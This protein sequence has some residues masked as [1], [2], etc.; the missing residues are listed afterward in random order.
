MNKA[1]IIFGAIVTKLLLLF[2]SAV[3]NHY[4]R[5]PRMQNIM[6]LII[7]LL[8]VFVIVGVFLLLFRISRFPKCK[9]LAFLPYGIIIS[10]FSNYFISFCF[11]PD[12]MLTAFSLVPN[13]NLVVLI[14]SACFILSFLT[15]IIFIYFVIDVMQD[16]SLRKTNDLLAKS[17][18]IK[19]LGAFL[20]SIFF[21]L[22]DC[23]LF[24]KKSKF[25]VFFFRF[26]LI[27]FVFVLLLELRNWVLTLDF[28]QE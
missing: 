1:K 15:D 5:E 8:D 7:S 23:A 12:R 16:N 22:K 11:F 20:L 26:V 25:Y 2:T 3:F 4:I 21:A 28:L 17:S 14:A 10:A 18:I 13:P 24:I 19:V 27:F 6:S 9:F